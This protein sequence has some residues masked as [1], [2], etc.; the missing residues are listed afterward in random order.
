LSLGD[1][2]DPTKLAQGEKDT[3]ASTSP[4][5]TSSEWISPAMQAMVAEGKIPKPPDYDE[6]LRKQ[7]EKEKE[8]EKEKTGIK[9]PRSSSPFLFLALVVFALFPFR[10]LLLFLFIYLS[11]LP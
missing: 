8:K 1:I 5:T 9:R 11:S 3:K 4:S 6:R 10:F 2:H 7:Q